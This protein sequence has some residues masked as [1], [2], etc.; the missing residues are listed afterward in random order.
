MHIT[1]RQ[2]AIFRAI[3]EHQSTTQ[4][5][6]V[7]C[8]SQSA[9]SSALS[10]LEKQLGVQIFERI[11][12][13]LVCNEYGRVLYPKCISVLEQAEEIE[14]LFKGQHANLHIGT[15]TT[16]GN[17]LMPSLM[18]KMIHDY[19]NVHFKLTVA[20]SKEIAE[21]ISNMN[22]DLG[23]IEGQFSH[24]DILMKPWQ[25]D[26]LVLFSAHHSQW[27]SHDEE[28]VNLAALASCPLIVRETG[29]GTRIA[30]EQQ[31]LPQMP[32]VNIGLE[33]GNSEAIKQAV[34]CDLGIGCLSK[35]VIEAELADGR[36]RILRVAIAPIYRTLWLLQNRHKH[37][38]ETLQIFMNILFNNSG[39]HY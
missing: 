32:K 10:D 16:I 4:A 21:G 19:P 38:S 36:L 11:G 37:H 27:V 2:L 28:R 33:L 1:L 9:V 17:Y 6:V 8:L 31:L 13:R 29:S 23:L 14:G 12:R 5:A 22:Y 34:L 30:V 15:S 26:E 35:H 24:P 20:N 39:V 3:L 18:A 7:L 25:S